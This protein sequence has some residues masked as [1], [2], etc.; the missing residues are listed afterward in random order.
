MRTE[1]GNEKASDR[2]NERKREE[3][4]LVDPAGE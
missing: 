3:L 2:E 4:V 1:G